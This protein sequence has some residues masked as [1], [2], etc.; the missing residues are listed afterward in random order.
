MTNQ[1]SNSNNNYDSF[2]LCN[3]L[4]L[5]MPA[6]F[7]GVG[8]RIVL[9]LLERL[10]TKIY[11]LSE[12]EY[13]KFDYCVTIT[14]N[15]ILKFLNMSDGTKNYNRISVETEVCKASFGTFMIRADRMSDSWRSR[16]NYSTDSMVPITGSLISAVVPFNFGEGK[17]S[18]KWDFKF[19]MGEEWLGLHQIARGGECLYY[20]KLWRN[21]YSL[22]GKYSLDIYIYCK[23][24]YGMFKKNELAKF[25]WHIN[26]KCSNSAIPCLTDALHLKKTDE[27]KCKMP[28]G[29][30]NE[31]ILTP[32]M[33][34]INDISDLNVSFSPVYTTHN[35]TKNYVYAINLEI[36]MKS[37]DAECF[38]SSSSD[39]E[40]DT[41]EDILENIYLE[42]GL[43]NYLDFNPVQ[44]MNLIKAATGK[45]IGQIHLD[46]KKFVDDVTSV[47]NTAVVMADGH[48][49]KD[50]YLYI[51]KILLTMQKIENSSDLPKWYLDTA[52][53]PVDKDTL[54]RALE[55][56][57]K[58]KEE[59]PYNKSEKVID[60]PE[61]DNLDDEYPF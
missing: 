27:G 24:I 28:Y 60:E 5:N 29:K 17:K 22:S 42:T 20:T 55:I 12:Q 13:E 31:R 59:A 26:S 44:V 40:F 39:E 30:L 48:Q 35:V 25:K 3:E 11:Y 47:L 33:K 53:K 61:L 41:K 10:Y 2:G 21:T 50:P 46:E 18:M 4:L 45:S 8:K 58:L 7:S 52:T 32:S 49:I 54:Q 19:N 16:Y 1:P 23:M 14:T 36:K 6:D 34:E 15:E 43:D 38:E 9:C 57:R 56:Q 51:K 37:I